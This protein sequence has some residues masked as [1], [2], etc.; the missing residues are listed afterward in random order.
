MGSILAG[1][2]L[3]QNMLC[4]FQ[5]SSRANRVNL[6]AFVQKAS[7]YTI[8]GPVFRSAMGSPVE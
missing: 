2:L 3:V 6:V 8:F 7:P 5:N 4:I 1:A